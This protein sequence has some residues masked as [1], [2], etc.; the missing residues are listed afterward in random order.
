[1]SDPGGNDEWG[2]G[3]YDYIE[4][5]T[6]QRPVSWLYSAVD[7]QSQ[8]ATS[9]TENPLVLAMVVGMV[10]VSLQVMQALDPLLNPVEKPKLVNDRLCGI[11]TGGM[12]RLMAIIIFN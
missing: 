6:W 1:M 4:Q 11:T 12:V 8:S 3:D 7:R 10:V 5:D 2:G 9:L